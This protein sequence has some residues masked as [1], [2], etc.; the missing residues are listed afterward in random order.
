M[1]YLFRVQAGWLF[2]PLITDVKFNLCLIYGK[3]FVA[4]LR[5]MKMLC[6]FSNSKDGWLGVKLYHF[7]IRLEA[8]GFGRILDLVYGTI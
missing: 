3:I 8:V 4:Y 1:L 6:F 5:S 2:C 7:F